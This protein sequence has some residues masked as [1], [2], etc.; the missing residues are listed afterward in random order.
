MKIENC[1]LKKSNSAFTLIE[2]LVA[3]A[4]VG[5]LAAVVM[6]QMSNYGEKAR[7]SRAMAQASSVI[8]Q[9]V[10]CAGNYGNDKV[11]FSGDICSSSSS[12]GS[13]PSWPSSDYGVAA[14]N[15]T[16]SSDWYF[17]ISVESGNDICC[18]S[19]MNSCGMPSVACSATAIW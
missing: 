10:S 6:V 12:Y 13:W 18:N 19:K 16:S 15:W 17:E 1:K 3:I 8:P 7:A 11:Q 14:S 5:I 2:I 4:I 9:M